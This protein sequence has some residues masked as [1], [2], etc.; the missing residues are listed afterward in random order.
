MKLYFFFVFV[1]VFLQNALQVELL[2]LICKFVNFVNTVPTTVNNSGS[3]LV[4]AEN[5]EH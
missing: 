2:I 1:L 3:G 4:T 5:S